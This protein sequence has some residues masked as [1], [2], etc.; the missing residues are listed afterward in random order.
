M[1]VKIIPSPRQDKRYRA[2][3]RRK[4]GIMEFYD[5]GYKGASTYIDGRTEEERRNYLA[6]HLGNK[7]EEELINNLVPSPSL[8]SVFLL[9]GKTRS[10]EKNA[11]YLNDLWKNKHK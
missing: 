5:F 4:N 1:I 11:R 6:R 7:T 8:L 10:L 2:Y 3:I 9:W